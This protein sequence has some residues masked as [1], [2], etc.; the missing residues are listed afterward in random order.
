[1]AGFT[2]RIHTVF[3]PLDP[4]PEEFLHV[5]TLIDY[6][7]C[8]QH[9]GQRPETSELIRATECT[10]TI[11]QNYPFTEYSVLGKFCL[12][13]TEWYICTIQTPYM[14]CRMFNVMYLSCPYGHRHFV[15]TY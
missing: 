13:V 6:F 12:N 14:L 3:F 9:M 8:V 10:S 15:R 2:R 1:M 11:G 7:K 5:K 4:V